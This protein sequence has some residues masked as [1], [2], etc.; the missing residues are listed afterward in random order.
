MIGE[1]IKAI[2]APILQPL[3]GIIDQAVPDKDLAAT[4]KADIQKAV[5][6]VQIKTLESQR[7]I[8]IAE[9]QGGSWLQRTWRP[10]FMVLLMA[11]LVVSVV[12]GMAGYGEDIAAG[13]DSI[14]DSAWLLMQIG[15]G[16]YIGGRTVEKATK[17]IA[18]AIRRRGGIDDIEWKK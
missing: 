5:I 18:P 10:M 14:N 11:S 8:I 1:V 16:G 3:F 7:D 9:A 15:L 17:T 6:D 12:G 4:L 2:A 13:W